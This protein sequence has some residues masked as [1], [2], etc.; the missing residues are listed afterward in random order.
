MIFM[1]G[2]LP[3]IHAG[4]KKDA[5]SLFV[6]LGAILMINLFNSPL[7]TRSSFSAIIRWCLPDIKSGHIADTK[8][9]KFSRQASC[10]SI[11]ARRNLSFNALSSTELVVA[12][13]SGTLNDFMRYPTYN[14]Y[15]FVFTDNYLRK[16][17]P[18]PP[19]GR[20]G[21]RAARAAKLGFRPL[22]CDPICG[23][24]DALPVHR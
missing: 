12:F 8:S 17:W 3:I 23:G 5:N 14:A 21:G 1:L 18:K 20:R 16:T 24:P 6:C 10:F 2:F 9:R 15:S 4:N 19:S 7:A 22:F 13:M 11:C